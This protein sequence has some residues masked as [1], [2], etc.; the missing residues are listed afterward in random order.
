MNLRLPSDLSALLRSGLS[1][2]LVSLF[3]KL[4]TAGLTYGMYVVMARAMGADDYGQFAFGLSLATILAIA[5]SMGQQTAVLRFWPQEIVAGH[6][7]KALAALRAGT[8]LTLGAGIVVSLGLILITAL[9]QVFAGPQTP[10]THIYAS[11]ALIVPMALAEYL[12][13]ALRA[14]GSVWT[15]LVPR[16][17]VW[18]L[19]APV[20]V[21]GLFVYGIHLSGPVALVVTAVLLALA[22]LF[23]VFLA[24]RRKYRTAPTLSGVGAY[25][26][27]RGA[28]SRWFLTGTVLDSAAL[29]VDIILVGLFVTA[30]SAGVYFN[31]FR[32]AGLLTIFMYAIT[33]V[34]APMVAQH[35]HAGEMRK[36]QAITALCAWAGFVFSL[37]V[38]I[39]FV[40]FGDDI[41]SLFG[42]SYADG[43][44]VLILLS[45]GLLYESTTGPTRIVMMMTGH[46]KAYVTIFGSITVIGIIVQLV[47]IPLFGV[48]AAAAINMVSRI[49]AQTAIALWSRRNIGIDTSLFGV[50]AIN[51]SGDSARAVPAAGLSALTPAQDKA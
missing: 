40:V 28:A 39:G 21:Y 33:L 43:H 18:R 5:A 51:S 1:K 26:R 3:I 14:Q 23:Q 30:A 32:T 8:S 17:I 4:A 44:L 9:V 7:E 15:A 24:S 29:N 6:P 31:A 16:D 49:I 36:A 19:S 41:L 2:S 10:V 42:E 37:V 38:F 34:I 25:W 20:L 13:A 45:I 35:Y 47:A 50:L 12:S 46:E 22:L 27:E 48:V 11:A